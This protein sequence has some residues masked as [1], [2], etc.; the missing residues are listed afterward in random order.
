VSRGSSW[1]RH[2]LKGFGA[3]LGRASMAEALDEPLGVVAG[4]ERADVV[5]RLV[6]VA[7][8]EISDEDTVAMWDG[9]RD[10]YLAD[11]AANGFQLR[12]EGPDERAGRPRAHVHPDAIISR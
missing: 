1:S 11:I 6:Q 4:D 2:L 10:N 12:Y 7:A 5:L 9:L 8:L 3:G